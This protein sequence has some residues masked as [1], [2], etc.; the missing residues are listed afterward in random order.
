MGNFPGHPEITG[1]HAEQGEGAKD[2]QAE[3]GH[4]DLLVDVEASNPPMEGM[5]EYNN[6]VRLIHRWFNDSAGGN[7]DPAA[8]P[9]DVA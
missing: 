3:H 1:S 9:G 2:G 8:F 4:N 6:K 7:T 5:G